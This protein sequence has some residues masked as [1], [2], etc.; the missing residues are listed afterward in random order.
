LY[1]INIVIKY[2]LTKTLAET[3]G[4]TVPG[5]A[6][7]KAAVE[8]RMRPDG[9]NALILEA[10]ITDQ[11]ALTCAA[12]T[13]ENFLEGKGIDGIINNT[14]YVSETTALKSIEDL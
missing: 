4:T 12:E 3:P 9:F 2:V 1:Y 11:P 10:D 13:V 8:N 14:G 6:R 5:L 7:N